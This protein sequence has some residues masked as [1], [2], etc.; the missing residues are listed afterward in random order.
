LNKAIR[1][2]VL[3]REFAPKVDA[4]SFVLKPCDFASMSEARHGNCS[5]LALFVGYN[6]LS[7]LG[8]KKATVNTH[9]P[10]D[11]ILFER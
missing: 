3:E 9:N 5:L 4:F 11:L 7:D 6:P 1:E 2:A 8:R 10:I